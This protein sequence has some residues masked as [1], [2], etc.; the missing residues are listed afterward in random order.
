MLYQE[1]QTCFALGLLEG[2]RLDF[3]WNKGRLGTSL[4]RNRTE[5]I[6][7]SENYFFYRRKSENI[8]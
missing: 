2:N 3:Y 8:F 4:D 6:A 5:E 7:F 1:D